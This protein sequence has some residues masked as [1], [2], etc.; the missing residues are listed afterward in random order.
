MQDSKFAEFIFTAMQTMILAAVPTLTG[1][2]I[3]FIKSK[4]NN[5]I[6]QTK[7]E[8]LRTGLD[9]LN[10]IICAAVEYTSQ[11]YV[12]ELKNKNIF[13]RQEQ[14]KALSQTKAKIFEQIKPE[15]MQLFENTYGD[16]RNYVELKIEEHIHNRNTRDN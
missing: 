13:T 7:N 11:T 14:I 16:I 15:F 4:I 8:K 3:A 12:D 2:I 1:F 9:D 5:I 6:F 10:N